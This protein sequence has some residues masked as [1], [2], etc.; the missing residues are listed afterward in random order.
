MRR[1]LVCILGAVLV[2][3]CADRGEPLKVGRKAFVEQ[4]ILAEITAA[5][6]NDVTG[7]VEIVNC[8]DTF[9]CQ[10]ALRQGSVDLMVEY[11]GTGHLYSSAASGGRGV[12]LANLRTSYE[13]LGLT[14]LDPLGFDNGYRVV[15]LVNR[16]T[17]LDVET[18]ADL[19]PALDGTVRVAV[20]PTYLRRPGDGLAALLQRHGL[21]LRGEAFVAESLEERLDALRSGLTDIAVVY[22]TDGA[23]RGRDIVALADS[24]DFFPPYDAA[25]LAR[26]EIFEEH[27]ELGP[28][29]AGLSGLIDDGDMQRLNYAA[30]IEGWAPAEVARRFL[31]QRGLV[32]AASATPRHQPALALAYDEDDD[33]QA[34][35]DRATRAIRQTFPDRPVTPLAT[36]DPAEAIARGSARL[37]VLGAE[38]FFHGAGRSVSRED[39]VEAVAVVGNRVV[40]VVRRREDAGGALDGRVGIESESGGAAA[41]ARAILSKSDVEVARTASTRDL[42]E[43][44]H[45]GALDAAVVVAELGAPELAG[46]LDERFALR[47]LPSTDGPLAAPYLRPA[48]VPADTYGAAE[49]MV[50]TLAAQVVLAGPSRARGSSALVGPAAALPQA[51]APLS[52]AEAEALAG[53]SGV[54][55]SPDPVLPSAWTTWPSGIEDEVQSGADP[56][57]VDTALNLGTLGFLA[58]MIWLVGRSEL[59][60]SLSANRED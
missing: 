21:R 32:E 25:V 8:G 39:R 34:A 53:A 1:A 57:W 52:L 15:M 3:G 24:L 12:S 28:A 20:P 11:T 26:Q 59:G 2:T 47:S 54:P 51:S 37:A 9:G 19:S 43:A 6:A 40:H 46:A 10:Q 56:S 50:D 45:G 42:L 18:I 7:E 41:I 31:E 55:E 35:L 16:A 5:I 27:A 4:A 14:W 60:A 48:R 29:L 44:V 36:R 38:R 33:L 17:A 23:L 58:W 49:G 13:P 22:A 30:Q